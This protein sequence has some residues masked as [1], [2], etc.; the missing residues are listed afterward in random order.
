MKNK[1]G[2]LNSLDK[3]YDA[4]SGSLVAA[5]TLP[6]FDF[7]IGDPRFEALMKKAGFRD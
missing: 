3:S 2:I 1:E 4:R 7:L 6:Q 5:N